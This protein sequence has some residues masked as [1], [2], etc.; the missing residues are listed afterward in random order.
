MTDKTLWPLGPHTP[1]KH[2]VL[3]HY[4]NAWIPI[5]GSSRERIVFIDG[6]AGPGRYEGGEEGSPVIALKTLRDHWFR[7]RIKAEMVFLFIEEKR[8]RADRLR[9]E[10]APLLAELGPG[11]R[12]EVHIGRFDETMTEALNLLDEQ[13]RRLAPAFV[14]IDPFGISDTP[15]NVIGRIL[16]IPE[17]EVYVSF[18]WEFFNRFKGT[19]EFPP[20]LD[21]LFGTTEW[22]EAVTARDWRERK[23]RIFALY[24]RQLRQAGAKYVVHFELYDGN[25]LVYAIFHATKHSRGCDKMKEAIWKIDPASGVAF[26]SSYVDAG[27]LFEGDLTRFKKEL[28]QEFASRGPVVV[29]S[30]RSW[31]ETDATDHYSGQLKQALREMED[32]KTVDVDPTTRA[33]KRQFPD[34]TVLTFKPL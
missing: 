4:L 2:A 24:K 10:I 8:D 20:H 33:R 1:G 9:A 28:R 7:P 11:V 23:R 5:L 32:E 6:F 17:S 30:V 21:E 25:S 19:D 16:Q 12:A 26:R 14:M 31:V 15:M 27:D 22:R 13:K 18:M 3:R 34:G 29:D